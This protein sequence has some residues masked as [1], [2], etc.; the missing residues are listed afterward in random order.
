MTTTFRPYH[1]DQ[2]FL[3]PPSLQDC[4]PEGHLVYFISDV[5]D[6]LHLQQLFDRYEADGRRNFP[7]HPARMVKVLISAYATGVM[8]SRE[9]A[10]RLEAGVSFRVLAANNSPSHRTICRFRKEHLSLFKD[11][12]MQ[13][14]KVA[15]Q[16]GQVGLGML[17]IGGLK[18]S[19][20]PALAAWLCAR[21]AKRNKAKDIHPQN[22]KDQ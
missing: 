7:Y 16:A 20:I 10:K 5:V 11:L 1:P 9:I 2:V 21:P 8:S 18:K 12:L 4:L 13:V 3:L 19:A 6:Q 17:L 22:L 15:R 14:V